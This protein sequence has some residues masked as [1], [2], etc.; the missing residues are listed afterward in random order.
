MIYM[1]IYDETIFGYILLDF[2]MDFLLDFLIIPFSE[3][4]LSEIL[5]ISRSSVAFAVSTA[6]LTVF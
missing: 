4:E 3:S 2:L 5:N 1:N 6:A